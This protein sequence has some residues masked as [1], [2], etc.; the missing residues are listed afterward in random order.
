MVRVVYLPGMSGSGQFWQPVAD[1]LPADWDHTLLDWPGLGDVPASAA[2]SSFDDLT[3]IVSNSLTE[4]SALVAQSMGGV[5]ATQVALHAPQAVTHLV[6]CATSGGI[7]MTGAVDWRPDYQ[8]IWPNAPHWALQP[9]PDRTAELRRL[10]QP[11]LLLWARDD[12]ISPTAIGRKLASVI[13]NAT[14]QV[15]PTSNHAFVHDSPELVIDAIQAHLGAV[16]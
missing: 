16:T 3:R 14:F 13:P 1:R 10:R 12:P 4:P 9:P 11:T 15:I 5:V 2:V 8:A 7:D 6:L